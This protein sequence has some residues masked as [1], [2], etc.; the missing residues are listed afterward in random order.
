MTKLVSFQRNW[1][2][3]CIHIAKGVHQGLP[4]SF[5]YIAF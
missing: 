2:T 5:I 1:N 4:W 3:I